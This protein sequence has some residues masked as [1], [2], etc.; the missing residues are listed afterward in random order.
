M[1]EHRRHTAIVLQKRLVLHLLLGCL[2]ISG[3]TPLKKVL[4]RGD[5]SGQEVGGDLGR[6][7]PYEVKISGIDP[8]EKQLLAALNETGT[9]MRLRARPPST[10]AGLTRRAEEDVGRF[11]AVLRSFGFYDGRAT[12]EIH[13]TAGGEGQS[14]TE[15]VDAAGQ[16]GQH[17]ASRPL[18]L[19]YRIETGPAYLLAEV[20]LHVVE[21]DGTRQQPMEAEELKKI[22]LS[23]GMRAKAE[24]IILAEQ[25]AVDGIR[26]K[27]YPLAKAGDRK[28]IADTAEKTL[29]VTYQVISG[30]KANFGETTVTGAEKV[31]PE[32]I[33]G[34]RSWQTG[35][36]FSPDEVVK[37]RRELAKSNLFSSASVSPA[38]SVN[39]Q[40]EIPIEI[41]VAERDHRTVGGGVDFSTADGI[42]ANAFWEHRNMFGAGERLRLHLKA[43]ELQQGFEAGL[44]K[45][46]FY[47]PDQALVIDGQGKSYN[48]AAYEGELADSFVGLERRFAEYWTATAGLTAEYSALTGADSPNEEFYLG[49]VRAVVRHDS[50]GNPLDP[51][52]GSR[53]EITAS[54]L[55]SLAG[56]GTQFVSLAVN[57][58]HYLPFDDAGHYVLAG[59]ARLGGVWGEERSALP[60]HKRF[61][62]GGGGSIRGYAYQQ[63]GPLDENDDP[64]GGRSVVEAGLE[65][66]ARV[67]ENIG[68]VPF[69]EGGNVFEDSQPEDVEMQWAAG[70]GLRYYTAIG[71]LRL[72]FAVPLDQRESIDD[73]FQVYLSIGQAF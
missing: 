8:Q 3:C 34:F 6:T 10:L 52:R 65:F 56:P 44:S 25:L 48:T 46:R 37:T 60:S 18:V 41:Q 15:A 45:P 28:V 47:R 59:R 4:G 61:Y 23:R 72:D 57:G 14:P 16:K 53:L 27:G 17:T 71:P 55:T 36:R 42:G 11:N 38:D 64:L 43:S 62:S 58:S 9:A 63:V 12:F 32:Y 50:T 22:G 49:G 39:D 31:D 1:S 7:V 73:D 35:A 51:T 70:L 68:V 69:I 19:E 30:K 26:G 29:N 5:E 54:P 20:N 40:G 67:A 24:S 21:P 33:A 2:L 66:R 13:E